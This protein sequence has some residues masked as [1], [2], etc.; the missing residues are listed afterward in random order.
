MKAK[1]IQLMIDSTK[2]LRDMCKNNHDYTLTLNKELQKLVQVIASIEA[3]V[4]E[5]EGKQ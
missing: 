3:R 1:E 4:S 5:L 2:L